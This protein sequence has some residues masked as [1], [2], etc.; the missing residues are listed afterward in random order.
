MPEN[1][2]RQTTQK[3]Q[4]LQKLSHAH[5]L[6]A[7]ELASALPE[8]DESTVYRNLNRLEEDGQL[9]SVFV[10]ETKKYEL[11]DK[12]ESSSHFVCDD[13]NKTEAVFLDENNLKEKVPTENNVSVIVRGICN[14]CLQS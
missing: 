14:T 9:E 1:R 7:Q 4:I 11:A 10:D 12:H 3:Q 5:L 2:R 6:S 13:C 8:I